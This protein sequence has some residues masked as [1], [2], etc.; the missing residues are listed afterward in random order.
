MAEIK[1]TN[2]LWQCVLEFCD[3]ETLEVAE[4][5]KLPRSSMIRKRV[6]LAILSL[7]GDQCMARN[8]H[9]RLTIT[10]LVDRMVY[11]PT[12]YRTQ[13]YRMQADYMHMD[14]INKLKGDD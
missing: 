3:L 10:D 7:R 5:M 1:A 13:W 11:K 8:E 9:R 14:D 4:Q 2:D 12:F 6:V